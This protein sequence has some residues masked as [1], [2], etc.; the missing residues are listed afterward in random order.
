MRIRSN[1]KF[2]LFILHINYE[3]SENESSDI[4]EAGK[5]Y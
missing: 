4:R 1:E 3:K 2:F 5:N